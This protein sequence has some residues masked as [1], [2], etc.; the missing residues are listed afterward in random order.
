MS[1]HEDFLSVEEK[2][3]DFRGRMGGARLVE[4]VVL[5]LEDCFDIYFLEGGQ[6]VYWSNHVASSI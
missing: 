3:A 5:L 2:G 6:L 1:A 4:W